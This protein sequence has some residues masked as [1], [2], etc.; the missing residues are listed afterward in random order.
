MKKIKENLQYRLDNLLSRSS[1]HQLLF[2]F[3]TALCIS[4]VSGILL[5]LSAA[6]ELKGFVSGFWWGMQKL[7]GLEV[8]DEMR[9]NVMFFAISIVVTVIGIILSGM[10]IA[11]LSNSPNY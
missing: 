9:K 11:I 10:I 8:S 6:E 4:V 2:L 5:K 3:L 7:V 1:A